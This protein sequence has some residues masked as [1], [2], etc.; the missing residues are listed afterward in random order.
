MKLHYDPSSS[1]SRRVRLAIALLGIAVDE[2]RIDL[3]SAADRATLCDLNPN[4][5]VPV[6]E[7]GDLVLWES[8]AIMQ[9]LCNRTSG[10]RLYPVDIAARADVDRWL[11]WISGQLEPAA[12]GLNLE[13]MWKP[14]IDGS[15]PDPA[16]VA[17]FEAMLHAAAQVLDRHLESRQWIAG[18]APSL[19]DLSVAATLMYRDPARLPVAP[20]RHLLDLLDRVAGLEAWPSTDPRATSG[21]S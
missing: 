1:C 11:F 8:H 15:V 12:R 9:Y 13:N 18:M 21:S 3:G 19:A 6:L 2:H 5:Q 20:Y 16:V 10:Q 17:R 4:G 14:Q 7:D